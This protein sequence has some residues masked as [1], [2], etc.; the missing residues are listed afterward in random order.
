[1]ASVLSVD[2]IADDGAG[3]TDVS[4]RCAVERRLESIGGV[5]D[6]VSSIC[7]EKVAVRHIVGVGEIPAIVPVLLT[8]TACEPKKPTPGGLK[9]V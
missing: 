5:D 1:M 8:L 2:E 4:N 3:V 9:M 7:V 6:G